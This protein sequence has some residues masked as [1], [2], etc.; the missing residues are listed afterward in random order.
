MNARIGAYGR[1]SLDIDGGALGV[2]RQHED[3]RQ[4]AERRGWQIVATYTDNN[5]SAYKRDVIRPDFERMISDINSGAIDGVVAYDLD[6][7]WRKP[8]D[9]ERIID[10]FQSRPSLIFATVQGDIDLSTSDG[11]T[12]ARIM[13]ALA[14]KSSAD[15]SRRVK[16]KIVEQA[17]TGEPHWSR[18]PYGYESKTT[19]DP[20]EAP[21]VRQMAEWF[22]QGFS[23]REITWRLNEQGIRTRAG[24]VWYVG[25]IR[26]FLKAERFAS[27]RLSGGKSYEGTWP[28]I[29]TTEEWTALQLEVLTR[30]GKFSG[31]PQ[32]KKYML[33]GILR[34][35]CG[36]YLRGMTKRDSL[37]RPLR[38]TYQCPTSSET[39]RRMATCAG[40]C[41]DTASLEHFIREQV[42]TQLESPDL[43]EIVDRDAGDRERIAAL[44]QE[45]IDIKT[46]RDVLLDDYTDSVITRDELKYT[47]DRLGA[48]KAAID[49]ELDK[50]QRAQFSLSLEPGE[51]VRQAWMDRPDG[52]RRALVELL[53]N[54]ITISKGSRKPYYDVDGRRTRFDKE[55]VTID[56]K[57]QATSL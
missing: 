40:M 54:E 18:R 44:R 48:R 20:I 22:M 47:Q 30:Q 1:I 45:A 11:R 19:L 42:L 17:E 9:L 10:L 8:S 53:I 2:A 55:R 46:R 3:S 16:R 4:L 26:Q 6:R 56:W 35:S 31:R 12:M 25:T 52:W 27:I 29:F 32:N 5:V 49:M 34:C 7:L 37:D 33:T 57:G 43:F 36:G 51:T 24:S 21:I 50:L 38:R 28:A 14:N 41:V 13:V 39:E 15:T 23:Y